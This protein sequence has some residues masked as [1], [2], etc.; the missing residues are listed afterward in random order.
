MLSPVPAIAGAAAVSWLLTRVRVALL[1]LGAWSTTEGWGG[2]DAGVR[3]PQ[4]PLGVLT[5]TE[6]FGC[7]GRFSIDAR[8][9]AP[10]EFEEE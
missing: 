6:V 3:G 10:E 5:P 8:A 4:G 2:V 9:V 1:A 7:L